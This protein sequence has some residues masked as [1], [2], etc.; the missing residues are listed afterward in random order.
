[1]TKELITH[2]SLPKYS[3]P[4]V[5]PIG[6]GAKAVGICADG[7]AATNSGRDECTNGTGASPHG[8]AGGSL[9]T[10]A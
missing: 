5:I 4:I 3:I 6:M 2:H 7:T 9:P 10:P 1:M 8:C